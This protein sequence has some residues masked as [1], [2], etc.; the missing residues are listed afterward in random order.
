MAG[1]DEDGGDDDRAGRVA[2][3]FDA[4]EEAEGEDERRRLRH[5]AAE[6]DP[7]SALLVAAD[8]LDDY[9]DEDDY[10]CARDVAQI[11]RMIEQRMVVVRSGGKTN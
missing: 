6:M 1:G 11:L 3:L 9:A 2:D 10:V 4:L 5:K 7:C 8:M